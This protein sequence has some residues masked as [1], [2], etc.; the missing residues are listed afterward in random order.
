MIKNYLDLIE[1]I[2]SPKNTNKDYSLTL[3]Q[4]CIL[5][6]LIKYSRVNENITYSNEIISEHMFRSKKHLENNLPIL[7]KKNLILTKVKRSKDDQ[8]YFISKRTIRINWDKLQEIKT[9]MEEYLSA[10]INEE[11]IQQE[12]RIQQGYRFDQNNEIQKEDTGP[13]EDDKTIGYRYI[14]KNGESYLVK[15]QNSVY[16]RYIGVGGQLSLYFL[17][18]NGQKEFFTTTYIKKLKKYFDTNG[19][20]F[21]DLTKQDLM[22]MN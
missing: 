17:N 22:N 9:E 18:Q 15:N 13:T 5:Q 6:R 1:W 16:M 14:E 20:E 8:G 2:R 3:F 4:S 11:N 7:T 10:L 12:E 21:K 19:V